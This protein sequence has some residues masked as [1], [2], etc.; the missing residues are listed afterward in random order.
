MEYENDFI[1]LQVRDMV[2]MLPKILFGKN[3]AK[4]HWDFMIISI[5]CL[6]NF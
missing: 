5:H 4:L 6:T 3:T 2:R 1:M